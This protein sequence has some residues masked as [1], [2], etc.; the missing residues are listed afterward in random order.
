MIKHN[1]INRI[2]LNKFQL[3]QILSELEKSGSLY[4]IT[5]GDRGVAAVLPYVDAE[6][7]RKEKI[8]N[9]PF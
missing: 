1:Q 6:A 2:D 4:I 3:T 5:K 8:K 9:I 7:M